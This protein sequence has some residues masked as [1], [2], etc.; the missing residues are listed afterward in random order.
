MV[1]SLTM[2]GARSA[3]AQTYA[4]VVKGLP[5]EKVQTFIDF[6]GRGSIMKEANKARG[7]LNIKGIHALDLRSFRPEGKP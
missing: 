3:L 6:Y 5:N 4:A 2:A 1:S 7:C